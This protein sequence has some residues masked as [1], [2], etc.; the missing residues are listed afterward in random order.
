MRAIIQEFISMC[1]QLF[2]Q[3]VIRSRKE[4]M[5]MQVVIFIEEVT[6]SELWDDVIT[7]NGEYIN[8]NQLLFYKYTHNLTNQISYLIGNIFTS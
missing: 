2:M 1:E 3:A 4:N 7:T 5:D 6:Y 8:R